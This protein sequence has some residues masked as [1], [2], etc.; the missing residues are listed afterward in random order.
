MQMWEDLNWPLP[1]YL[2]RDKPHLSVCT[3][4][5][6][7]QNSDK[8]IWVSDKKRLHFGNFFYA[9]SQRKETCWLLNS[10]LVPQKDPRRLR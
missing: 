4:N 10:L 9:F 1:I 6:A 5:T 7:L 8:D 3:I 2:Y